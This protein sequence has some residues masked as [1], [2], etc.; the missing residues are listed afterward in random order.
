MGSILLFI[1]RFGTFFLFL[2]LELVCLYL[3]INY[4]KSQQDIFLNSSN[5]VAGK[6]F[7]KFAQVQSFVNMSI[8]ADSLAVE[9][10]SLYQEKFNNAIVLDSLVTRMD[11]TK[12][13]KVSAARVINNSITSSSNYLTIDKGY[14]DGI[15]EG[16]GVITKDGIVGIVKKV[17]NHYGLVLSVLNDEFKLSGAIRSNNYFGT[18][19]WNEKDPRILELN[20]LPKHATVKIG[21]TI[22]T[23]G[24]SMIFPKGYFI[25]IVGKIGIMPGTNYYSLDC[26]TKVDIAKLNQVYVIIS[27]FAPE[28]D[29][30]QK[31]SYESR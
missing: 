17:S 8:V 21:D 1:Q 26:K 11:S 23:S 7:D 4:N 22:Q 3:I 13:F 5:I 16:Q 19:T 29:Q 15:R 18:V 6:V 10:A 24:F 9:N 20:D 27:K 28:L 31:D 2:G 30:L 14:L 25:G 12:A